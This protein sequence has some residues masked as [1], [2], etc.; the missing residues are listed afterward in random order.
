MRPCWSASP[1]APDRNYLMPPSNENWSWLRDPALRQ[2]FWDPIKYIRLRDR[3]DDWYLSIGGQTRQVWERIG[4]DNWGEQPF[5]NAFFLQRYMVHADVHYG[6]H[7]RSFVQL[8]SGIEMFRQGGP[9]PIDEKRLD[10][11]A[12][13][14]DIC[15]GGER[16]WI[17]FRAGRQELNYGSG[18]LVSVREGPNVRQS[19]DGFKIL[20]KAGA[21]NI[22]SF[23]VRPDLDDFGFFDNNPNHQISFWGIYSTRPLRRDISVDLYYLGIARK[24]AT[25]NRGTA[26]EL[27]HSLGARL[28]RPIAQTDGGWDFDYEGVWQFGSFGAANI[29]AWTCASETGYS[30]PALPLKPRFSLRADIS[31]GDDPNTGALGTFFPLFPIGNYFGVLADT[32]PGPMNFIDA[33]PR[34]QTVFP[35]DVSVMTDLVLYWRH[36]VLD[37]VYNVP[38]SLIRAAGNSRARFVGY[39]PGVEVRWQINRH[40]Y[41][42]ADYGIFYAGR[43]LRETMPG[44]NLNYLAFWAGYKF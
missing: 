23:A 15:S 19:F 18:R 17:A 37:G 36:S 10:F 24:Q 40:A 25:Y 2:D 41:L 42:Q 11:E 30:V 12:A 39:R 29:R 20:S 32:G 14:L 26:N 38:G 6:K 33:H 22:D 35:H 28:S 5:Q 1:V 31:S 34:I 9:R 8:K 21:W 7:F 13:F 16:N 44:R 43:F 3:R 27:R 4:N